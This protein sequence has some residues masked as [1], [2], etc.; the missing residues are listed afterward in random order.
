MAKKLFISYKHSIN[1]G[2]LYSLLP[3]LKEIFKKYGR[4]AK[5]FQ[6]INMPGHYYAGA[7]HPTKDEKGAE[8]TMNK[9]MFE[10]VKPLIEYQSYVESFDIW[11]GQKIDVDFDKMRSGFVNMPN[12]SINRWPFYLFPD[13]ATDLSKKWLEVPRKIDQRTKGKILI[14][15]TERYRNHMIAY[16][17]LK[18]YSGQLI[19]TGTKSEYEFFCGEWGL[20]M[21][22]LEVTDFL[23]LAVAINSCKLFV[24]NQSSA[25]Q[26]AEGL[27]KKRAVELCSFAPNVVPHGANGYDYYHQEAAEYY[28]KNLSK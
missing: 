1:I 10:M 19:F 20:E 15:F 16:F 21:P 14:N 23:E 4:K 5:V 27:K 18:E 6:R 22:Y 3:S 2:D 24:G 8:V 11:T 28:L 7:T 9:K 25:F 12:G 26:I 17:F 13:M